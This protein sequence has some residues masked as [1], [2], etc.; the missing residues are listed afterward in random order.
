MA[1][2]IMENLNTFVLEPVPQVG[3]HWST[4]SKKV[5]KNLELSSLN[6]LLR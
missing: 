4:W 2:K 3:K 6:K 1:N 5:M